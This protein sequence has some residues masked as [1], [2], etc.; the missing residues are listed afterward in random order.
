MG[1]TLTPVCNSIK[2]NYTTGING[3]NWTNYVLRGKRLKIHAKLYKVFSLNNTWEL[4][5]YLWEKVSQMV[6]QCSTVIS[7][8]NMI[9]LGFC[10]LF[11]FLSRFLLQALNNVC[12][13][14]GW[15]VHYIYWKDCSPFQRR[16]TPPQL[17]VTIQD[18][19]K[20]R[21]I[22]DFYFSPQTPFATIC[23]W[24]WGGNVTRS[25][26]LPASHS[27]NYGSPYSMLMT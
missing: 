5:K 11:F 13:G 14:Q 4:T 1:S 24:N 17:R 10:L 18:F 2:C 20:K 19:R 23:P 12:L 3:F 15:M 27:F 21:K 22:T 8:A 7:Y 16:Y 25:P 9:T 6:K 26:F